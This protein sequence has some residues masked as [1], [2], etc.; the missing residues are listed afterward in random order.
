MTLQGSGIMYASQV[1]TELGR[2]YNT[3]GTANDSAFRTLAGVPSGGYSGANFYGKTNAWVYSLGVGATSDK[4]GSSYGYTSGSFG[5]ISPT[6]FGPTGSTFNAISY[7]S[8]A[9][10][11]SLV[12]NGT[13]GNSGWSSITVNGYNYS[14]ASGSY[15]TSGGT[16]QWAWSGNPIGTSGTINVTVYP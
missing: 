14:R 15:G 7:Y 3:Y 4:Y 11:W 16:T 10:L 12:I 2:A 5:S 9:D 6:T 8:I 13:Y 1:N